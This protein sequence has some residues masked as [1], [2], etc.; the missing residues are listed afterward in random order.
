MAGLVAG[1]A[2]IMPP[3]GYLLWPITAGVL[4]VV[5]YKRRVP[6]TTVSRG[7]GA[8]VGAV[9]GLFGFVLFAILTAINLAAL[10]SGK[11]HQMMQ[12]AFQQAAARNPNPEAQAM[13]QRFMTPEG[14]AIMFVI[15]FIF[16]LM[17]FV[18]FS[19]LG[20][21][22]GAALTRPRAPKS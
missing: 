11:I 22:I 21:A 3:L 6:E 14:I 20:G 15:V 1:L 10:G 8:R 2:W 9:T 16:F 18:G 19:S 5:L 13:M 12:Q 17:I 7:A 4:A